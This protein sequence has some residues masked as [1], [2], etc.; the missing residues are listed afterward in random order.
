MIRY[1]DHRQATCESNR[2]LPHWRQTGGLYFVTFRLADSIP[3]KYHSRLIN[4]RK[5]FDEKYRGI[6]PFC[7]D[8]RE[9]RVL[10]RQSHR[11]IEYWLHQRYGSC[12]LVDPKLAQIV[13]SSLRYFDGQRYV[14]GRWV[15]AANHVHVLVCPKNS[16]N[17]TFILHSWKSF[18]ANQCNRAL[19]RQGSFWMDET[20]DSLVRSKAQLVHYENYIGAHGGQHGGLW[21]SKS[22]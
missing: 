9:R 12:V 3:P 15:V 7:L 6:D 11:N 4:E 5:K 16:C 1:F 18:S 14:L 13:S 10:L 8:A 2:N 19:K 22:N 20:F 17:L 21:L